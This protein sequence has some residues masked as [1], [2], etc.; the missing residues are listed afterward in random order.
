MDIIAFFR[1]HNIIIDTNN[2]PCT[3]PFCS[4]DNKQ[5]YVYI[6]FESITI[7]NTIQTG[8]NTQTN[9]ICYGCLKY[10]NNLLLLTVMYNSTYCVHCDEHYDVIKYKSNDQLIIDLNINS[11][12][13][14]L[15]K[16]LYIFLISVQYKIPAKDPNYNRIARI[17]IANSGIAQLE[18]NDEAYFISCIQEILKSSVRAVQNKF[19]YFMYEYVGYCAILSIHK[20]INNIRLFDTNNVEEIKNCIANLYNSS[21]TNKNFAIIPISAN[22]HIS[23]LIVDI[24]VHTNKLHKITYSFDS[25]LYHYLDGS[26]NS[27]ISDEH[28]LS[29]V[30]LQLSNCCGYWTLYCVEECI[31][32]NSLEQIK[33]SFLNWKMQL[34]IACRV[35]ALIDAKWQSDDLIVYSSNNNNINDIKELNNYIRINIKDTNNYFLLDKNNVYKTTCFNLEQLYLKVKEQDTS[36]SISHNDMEMLAN[37]VV[38]QKYNLFN[39][40]QNIIENTF[41]ILNKYKPQIE[42]YKTAI[43]TDNETA[44]KLFCNYFIKIYRYSEILCNNVNMQY[45]YLNDISMPQ[46]S[47]QYKEYSILY[48]QN[49]DKLKL[50]IYSEIPNYL[51]EYYKFKDTN[52]SNSSETFET[53]FNYLYNY[54]TK[55]IYGNNVAKYDNKNINHSQLITLQDPTRTQAPQQEIQNQ[56]NNKQ[57]ENSNTPQMTT[58]SHIKKQLDKKEHDKTSQIVNL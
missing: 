12:K 9:A 48:K 21:E 41:N 32:M 30:S 44:K 52:L 51:Q 27:M 25:S 54:Y 29:L 55:L 34:N 6:D 46:N 36:L 42:L 20:N 19:D 57:Q 28:K 13:D 2:L 45:I 56:D 43:T 24:L 17:I 18:T 47:K 53:Y 14:K 50:I 15:K 58:L 38:K 22:K 10:T 8:D 23:T 35:S 26:L 31:K 5:Y 49:S 37:Q 3:F 11:G 40:R 7:S 4:S 1:Q 33:T 39:I 16:M